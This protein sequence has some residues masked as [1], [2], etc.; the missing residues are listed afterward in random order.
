[1]KPDFTKQGLHNDVAA[2]SQVRSKYGI[3]HS[4]MSHSSAQV[5]I[6]ML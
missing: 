1:M 2:F 6:C 5:K 4:Y 3:T